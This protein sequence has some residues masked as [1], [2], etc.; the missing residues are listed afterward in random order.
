MKTIYLVFPKMSAYEFKNT[1]VQLYME[2]AVKKCIEQYC[3]LGFCIK[4]FAE[5]RLA[6]TLVGNNDIVKW[7]SLL[8][9]ND[10]N[11]FCNSVISDNDVRAVYVSLDK[12]SAGDV[13]LSEAKKKHP[14]PSRKSCSDETAYDTKRY[15]TMYNR[16]KYVAECVIESCKFVAVFKSRGNDFCRIRN[17]YAGDGRFTAV[18]DLDYLLTFYEYGGV[19]LNE[20][21]AELT[22]RSVV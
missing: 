15:N 22:L 3:R 10:A 19:P 2:N 11:Y 21:Q 7:V 5:D 4:C 16:M 12:K 8:S 6:L 18:F 14:L 17:S 13:Y 9:D 20:E 1:D